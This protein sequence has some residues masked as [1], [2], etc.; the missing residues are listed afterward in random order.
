MVIHYLTL[1]NFMT[2]FGAQRMD[3][4][5]NANNDCSITVVVAP[6][7]SGKTTIIRALKFLLYGADDAGLEAARCVN[8]EKIRETTSGGRVE[9]FVEAEITY[10]G[11]KR[12]IRRTLMAV[13]QGKGIGEVQILD[14]G[15]KMW[16]L[17]SRRDL[18]QDDPVVSQGILSAMVPKGLF[19]FFFFKGEELA[20]K[21]IDPE[22]EDA[23]M[24]A[25][26]A[27]V[28]YRTQWDDVLDTLRR[29]TNT[30]AGR[31]RDATGVSE[32]FKKLSLLKDA[33][34][35]KRDV[36]KV[37]FDKQQKLTTKLHEDYEKLD[38]Q[39]M[40][41]K[42]GKH[43]ELNEKIRSR[44]EMKKT[45][46][47]QIGDF[48]SQLEEAV[49]K[50]GYL[51]F[52]ESAFSRAGD[53]LEKMR[54]RK[55]LPADISEDFFARLLTANE[56]V[57]K[58]PLPKGSAARQEIELHK[59]A[60]LSGKLS[61]DLFSLSSRL[62]E[63]SV[64]GYSNK[65]KQLIE[66]IKIVR[67]KLDGEIEKVA[68][69]ESEI[70]TL[71]TE[72]DK[73]SQADYH[74]L[75]KKR[76]EANGNHADAREKLAEIREQI[77][78]IDRKLSEIQHTLRESGHVPEQARIHADSEEMA[79]KLTEL[80]NASAKELQDSLYSFLQESVAKIYDEIVTDSSKA[81]ID[82]DTLLPSIK[83][84]GVG[85][86]ASGGGQQQ[87]LCLAYII[88]LAELRKRVNAELK[89]YFTLRDVDDQCFFM[90]SVFA[91]MDRAYRGKVASA[92]P[93]KMRQLVLLLS[94]QQWDSQVSSGLKGHINN[95]YYFH[96]HSSNPPQEAA[97]REIKF[98]EHPVHLFKQ[99]DSKH[100]A[101]TVISKLKV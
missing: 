97:E 32:Q 101:Y 61:H 24:R 49:G 100:K 93:G 37:A 42:S 67:G 65:R 55:L 50:N 57:C 90:D 19:D 72:R 69:F 5:S 66:K 92:L 13:K 7:N 77:A 3:F 80:V 20:A 48:R 82:E 40:A 21:L 1:N 27:D 95:A 81:L 25:G 94:G 4:V 14:E 71:E 53:V 59:A 31:R 76:N 10:R 60:S 47:G 54:E 45:S 22:N 15:L 99:V 51:F 18:P 88:S 43:E 73:D 86:F 63:D 74:A 87:T 83:R 52:L 26:L 34:H 91:P 9:A 96:Y 33:Q 41:S 70:Q 89:K 30:F 79:K 2:M 46:E 29:V 44:R 16:R 78:E 64:E 58:A 39:V 6:N 75:V 17:E 23:D 62:A 36:L 84:D 8:L 12:R 38:A 35:E 68:R 56:C 85:G 11:V 98:Y 28:F